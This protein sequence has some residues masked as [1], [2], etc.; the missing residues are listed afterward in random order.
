MLHNLVTSGRLITLLSSCVFQN[1]FWFWSEHQKKKNVFQM[2]QKKP[3]TLLLLSAKTLQSQLS[4]ICS[5]N[6]GIAPWHCN[7]PLYNSRGN[8]Q[9]QSALITVLLHQYLVQ[10][11]LRYQIQTSHQQ[12]LY[13]SLL[14]FT[15]N[16]L[17][18]RLE[19]YVLQNLSAV[20]T[21]FYLHFYSLD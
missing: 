16:C 1:V 17:L 5:A 20:T 4:A 2:M 21:G 13:A 8:S 9:L 11:K 18:L 7:T 15:S 10:F 6:G 3:I 19:F 14:L 12:L